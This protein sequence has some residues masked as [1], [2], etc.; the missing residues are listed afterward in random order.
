VSWN[1]VFLCR[2]WFRKPNRKKRDS[3]WRS[4]NFVCSTGS[5]SDAKFWCRCA[6]SVIMA[7]PIGRTGANGTSPWKAPFAR[8]LLSRQRCPR[9]RTVPFQGSQSV[10][11]HIASVWTDRSI[12]WPQARR[13]LRPL[14]LEPFGGAQ[15]RRAHVTKAYNGRVYGFVVIR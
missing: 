4:S 14:A 8:S 10:E 1:K 5:Q 9:P 12:T 11:E 7:V 15:H 3:N 6:L 13:Q 2:Q